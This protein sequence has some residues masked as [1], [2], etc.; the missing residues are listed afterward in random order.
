MSSTSA[1]EKIYSL[2]LGALRKQ[3]DQGPGTPQIIAEPEK[4][5]CAE[6]QTQLAIAQNE[7][8]YA[9]KALLDKDCT[10]EYIME[11]IQGLEL[12]LGLETMGNNSLKDTN[13]A[14]SEKVAILQTKLDMTESS[15]PP[16]HAGCRNC[17]DKAKIR[18]GQV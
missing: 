1:L 13:I 3:K 11:R 16:S 2:A 10:Y 6:L 8:D 9:K 14:L 7:R 12:S 17:I 18:L 5:T 4:L 15:S